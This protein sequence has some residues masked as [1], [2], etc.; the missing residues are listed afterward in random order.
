MDFTLNEEHKMLQATVR[1]LATNK[2]APVADEL[3][4][5][6]EFAWD[7]FKAMGDLGLNGLSIP[8]EYGG[9]GGGE[10]SIAIA[11][12]EIARACAA[13]A[14]ILDTHLCLCT[15]LSTPTV[16][17]NSV[18][19]LSRPWQRAKRSVLLPLLNRKLAVILHP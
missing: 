19:S 8:S 3:D 5:K 18:R 6:Q 2:F 4:R 7:N 14:V 9:R 16:M 15:N 13:T 12:E 10:L 17:K 1:D 11:V